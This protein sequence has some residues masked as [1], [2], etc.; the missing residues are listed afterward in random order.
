VVSLLGPTEEFAGGSA[1]LA[2]EIASR[3]AVA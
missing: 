1:A 3:A 2:H